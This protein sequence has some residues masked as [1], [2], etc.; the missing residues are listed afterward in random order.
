MGK[1]KKSAKMRSGEQ[2]RWAGN[3][4]LFLMLKRENQA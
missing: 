4:S 3:F 2:G 1:K